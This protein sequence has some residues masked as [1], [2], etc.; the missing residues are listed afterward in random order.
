MNFDA[1]GLSESLLRAVVGEGY[2][3]P[4]PIQ[5]QSIPH[6]LAGSDVLA[7]AQT[8]TGKTAAFSL[9]M[10]QRLAPENPKQRR[11]SVVR[12][13][14]LAPT[15]ELACQIHDSL[16]VYGRHLSLRSTVV[17]GGVGMEPQIRA[18][19][20]GVDI[21]IATPGRLCDL[22]N[23]GVA[24]LSTVEML[25]LDEADRMLDMGFLPDLRY[26]IRCLPT[27][28]QT[29]MFSAT[30]PPA[31][32]ELAAGILRD[33]VRVRIAPVQSTTA[34]IDH[35][36]CFVPQEHKTKLLTGMLT[37]EATGRVIVFTRTK[38]GA[39][40]VAE[41]LNRS[42]VRAEAMH[43]NKSQGAR[44]RILDSFKSTRPPVLVATD[45]AARGI[46]VDDVS[47]VFNFDL[48]DEPETYV[49]RTGR[50]GRAG[51]AGKAMSF[52][53]G[54]ERSQLNAI[55]RLMQRKLPVHRDSMVASL[56]P[57]A[58]KQPVAVPAARGGS[59]ANGRPPFPQNRPK[60]GKFGGRRNSR[61]A[62]SL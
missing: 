30:L 5:A 1:L 9:P 23:Q 8:G 13:L 45:L 58:A 47:H 50:T 19:Q 17:M 55:E 39:D 6:V 29:V 26:V 20:R 46:D 35:A 54:G 4:T 38:R 41:Q 61:R 28:R 3:A 32:A 15:R 24:K 40:R 16:R 49:H 33:P 11:N 36:V 27:E 43:G 57:I 56:P 18:L 31:I 7:S 25:V 22:I 42:G 48:P 21:V 14:V 59:R 2:T 52:C 12:G 62:P 60:T 53:S 10:L 44:R 37:A 51:A 34:L